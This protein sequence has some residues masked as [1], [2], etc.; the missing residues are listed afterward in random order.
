MLLVCNFLSDAIGIAVL[1]ENV[2]YQMKFTWLFTLIVCL[3]TYLSIGLIK[4]FKAARLSAALFMLLVLVVVTRDSIAYRIAPFEAAMSFILLLFAFSFIFPW[5]LKTV[6]AVSISHF[7]AYS[8]YLINV[9]RYDYYGAIVDTAVHDYLSGFIMLFLSSIVSCAVVRRE[10]LR[11]AENFVLLK[12]V[13][14]K[15][16]QMEKELKLATRVHS[17]LIPHSTST[18]LAD[19][20]VTYVPM[21]YIGGDYAKFHLLGKNRLI[22]IICDVTGH[23]VSAALTVN[24]LNTE[25]DRL[26][27]EIDAPGEILKAI[28]RFMINNFSELNIYTSAFCGLLDFRGLSRK[29]IYSSYGHLPQ[30]IYRSSSPPIE[31]LTAQASLLGLPFNDKKLYQNEIALAKNDSILLFTDGVI[32]SRNPQGSEYGTDKVESYIKKNSRLGVDVFNDNL[33]H[34]LKSFSHNR[35]RDDLFILNI[36]TK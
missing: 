10:R 33:L 29:F 12:K 15:N 13:E 6:I 31:R 36:R 16:R 30:Y 26:S 28:N 21:Y 17:K 23:G 1:Q 18:P 4:T 9:P 32:E 25:F 24:V 7:L 34:E 11:D 20:A 19:I 14:E 8:I 35:I 2:T 27:R 22:F 5:S 3:V